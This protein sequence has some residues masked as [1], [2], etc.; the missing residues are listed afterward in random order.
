MKPLV[1][2]IALVASKYRSAII[3]ETPTG[4][5]D[6]KSIMGIFTSFVDTQPVAIHI[7][8]DDADEARAELE[9]L[10]KQ[11]NVEMQFK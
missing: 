6:G 8:G 9:R 1:T 5:I 11:L 4:M 3:L 10:F 2:E 7:Q